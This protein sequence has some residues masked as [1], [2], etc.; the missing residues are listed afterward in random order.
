MILH[1]PTHHGE[2]TMRKLILFLPVLLLAA[3]ER[4]IDPVPQP[5]PTATHTSDVDDCPR[6]DG[7]PCR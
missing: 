7:Q 2:A 4:P 5:E 6:A 1:P 3:C